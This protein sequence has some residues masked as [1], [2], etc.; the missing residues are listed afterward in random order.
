MIN[1][2]VSLLVRDDLQTEQFIE[3]LES[4]FKQ[5]LTPKLRKLQ[6]SGLGEIF[7]KHSKIKPFSIIKVLFNNMQF[8]R[9]K[10]LALKEFGSAGCWIESCLL[11]MYDL[12]CYQRAAL[13]SKRIDNCGFR[14]VKKCILFI[15]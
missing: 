5:F 3:K 7:R 2:D 4:D 15:S 14:V 8:P 10:Q 11:T 13:V 1:L 12:E 6:I 9:L